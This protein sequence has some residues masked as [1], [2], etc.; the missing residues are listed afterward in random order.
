MRRLSRYCGIAAAVV[1]GGGSL[2]MTPL[3]AQSRGVSQR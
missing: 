1:E 2:V 3:D